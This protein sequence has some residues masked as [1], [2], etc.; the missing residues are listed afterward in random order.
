MRMISLFLYFAS[1]S[2]VAWFAFSGN[3]LFIS[4]STRIACYARAITCFALESNSFMLPSC[5]SEENIA[6]GR[7]KDAKR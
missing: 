7:V 1:D 3:K 2:S 4:H 6:K 5:N